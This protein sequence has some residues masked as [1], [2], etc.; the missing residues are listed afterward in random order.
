MIMTYMQLIIKTLK[1]IKDE[2]LTTG[3][4]S[5]ED[6]KINKKNASYALMYLM[7]YNLLENGNLPIE[8]QN[9]LQRI[10]N[11]LDNILSIEGID[12]GA[13]I[14]KHMAISYEEVLSEPFNKDKLLTLLSSED[15]TQ[16][17][18]DEF[19]TQ[20][21][22]E[23]K[24]YNPGDCTVYYRA[25]SPIEN[26]IWDVRYALPN[27][28]FSREGYK[29]IDKEYQIED[30]DLRDGIFSFVSD[31]AYY[32]DNE[33]PNV[34]GLDED[35]KLYSCISLVQYILK[36]IKEK[37]FNKINRLLKLKDAMIYLNYYLGHDLIHEGGFFALFCKPKKIDDFDG[38]I[39]NGFDYSLLDF[40]LNDDSPS[41]ELSEYDNAILIALY[42]KDNKIDQLIND[43]WSIV[44]SILKR[45]YQRYLID[46]LKNHEKNNSKSKLECK[47]TRFKSMKRI[48]KRFERRKSR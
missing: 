34:Y 13:A 31:L 35:Q 5:D 9:N 37:Q 18:L 4:M 14:E 6:I 40:F 8:Q 41:Y 39:S 32:F 46:L 21:A 11:Y 12:L 27:L 24:D 17:E 19:L 28:Y 45:F 26:I 22:K 36:L 29:F 7:I 15:T 38:V 23:A 48:L 16:D 10:F 30:D 1:F 42:G 20:I 43:D 47:V 44:L 3:C 33:D 25:M 2:G